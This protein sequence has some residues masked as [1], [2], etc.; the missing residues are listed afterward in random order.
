MCLTGLSVYAVVVPVGVL[1]G[2][3]VHHDAIVQHLRLDGPRVPRL[4]R[5]DVQRWAVRHVGVQLGFLRE[6]LL[7]RGHLRDDADEHRLWLA[8]QGLR[9]L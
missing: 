3:A 2:K 8:R 4:R 6:R 9:G 7:H 1:P 5:L